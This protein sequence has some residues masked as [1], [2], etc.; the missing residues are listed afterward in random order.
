MN[1]QYFQRPEVV[2]SLF[3]LWRATHDT[4]YREWGWRIM[5]AIEKHCRH[6]AGYS[7]VHDADSSQPNGDDV[8][9]SWFLA[10]T[11]KY[12]FLL[13]SDDSLLSLDEWVF[14]T[15]AHP[16]RAEKSEPERWVEWNW[17]KLRKE[18]DPRGMNLET[19]S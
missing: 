18:S 16:V 6:E 9:Q 8:Q 1:R 3:Y 17:L 10:E 5:E 12:L 15:E 14:N 19:K 7:G 2:E 11:L 13:Y 4:T